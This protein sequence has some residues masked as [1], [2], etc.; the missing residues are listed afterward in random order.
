VE[1]HSF[2]VARPAVDSFDR[3]SVSSGN[4]IGNQVKLFPIEP[5]GPPLGEAELPQSFT[6]KI[7]IGQIS[8]FKPTILCPRQLSRLAYAVD[9]VSINEQ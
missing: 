5:Y 3:K 4:R 2:F 9:T 1:W 7:D 8:H 6:D